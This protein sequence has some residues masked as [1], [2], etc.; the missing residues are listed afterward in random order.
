MTPTAAKRPTTSRV[1]STWGGRIHRLYA[2][3]FLVDVIWSYGLNCHHFSYSNYQIVLTVF[4]NFCPLHLSLT[5]TMVQM[6]LW[7]SVTVL[8]MVVIITDSPC[9]L[10]CQVT[11][12]ITWGGIGGG[13]GAALAT[14]WGGKMSF[15]RGGPQWSRLRCRYLVRRLLLS[16]CILDFTVVFCIQPLPGL[17]WWFTYIGLCFKVFGG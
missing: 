6:T 8:H 17:V 13:R 7:L 3:P 15:A 1:M 11:L 2:W 9:I 4:A 5:M 10:H 12:C 14:F 16:C